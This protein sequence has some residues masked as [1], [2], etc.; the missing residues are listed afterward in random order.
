MV[1]TANLVDLRKAC[2]NQPNNCEAAKRRF[3]ATVGQTLTNIKVAALFRENLRLIVRPA[4]SQRPLGPGFLF[5]PLGKHFTVGW[6][7]DAPNSMVLVSTAD[8]KASG[9]S[10]AELDKIGAANL[11]KE[12]TDPLAPTDSKKYPG[13]FSTQGNDY[14][15]SVLVD[16]PFWKQ[17]AGPYA[18]EDVA[19]CLERRNQ[20]VVYVPRLDPAKAINF[21]HLCERLAQ[22]VTPPFSGV[23]VWRSKGKWQLN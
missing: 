1:T 6:A 8:T 17:V 7:Q 12:K 21:T 4:D 16:E 5:R 13:V 20:L 22:S 11:L 15:S 10:T 23:A 18:N 9:L 2:Q 19:I 14:L 3:V